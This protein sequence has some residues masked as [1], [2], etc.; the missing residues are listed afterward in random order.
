MLHA[1]PS[2]GKGQVMLLMP[3]GYQRCQTWG[4]VDKTG[5]PSLEL[6]HS[7][8]YR[9]CYSYS[10]RDSYIYDISMIYRDCIP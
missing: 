9:D 7:M 8:M 6:G 10:Y 2:H 5:P 3:I 4:L 1:V